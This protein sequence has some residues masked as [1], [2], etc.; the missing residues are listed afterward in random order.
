MYLPELGDR[1][2]AFV[3]SGINGRSH[4]QRYQQHREN[5][6]R[7]D[8]VSGAGESLQAL[9]RRV[10]SD[11]NSH[12]EHQQIGG[13]ILHRTVAVCGNPHTC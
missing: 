6:P 7:R 2:D 5:E 13:M 8:H 4:H 11:T 3:H 9:S 10:S 1:S 12:E